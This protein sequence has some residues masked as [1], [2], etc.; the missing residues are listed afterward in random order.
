MPPPQLGRAGNVL[1]VVSVARWTRG[2]DSAGEVAALLWIV[3][4]LIG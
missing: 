3:A 4:L 1:E 2:G